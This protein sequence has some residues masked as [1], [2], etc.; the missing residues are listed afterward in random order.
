MLSLGFIV[1]P[2]LE[3]AVLDFLFRSGGARGLPPGG[4]AAARLKLKATQAR[5]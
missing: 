4:T 1:G 3:F 2:Q 5:P